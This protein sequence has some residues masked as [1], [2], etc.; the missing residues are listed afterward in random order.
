MW[1]SKLAG[2]NLPGFDQ[3]SAFDHRNRNCRNMT[4]P[5]GLLQIHRRHRHERQMQ[6]RESRQVKEANDV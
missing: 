4:L 5:S 3:N 6:Q 2:R 1:C